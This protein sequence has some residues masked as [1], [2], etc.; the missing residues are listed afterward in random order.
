MAAVPRGSHASPESCVNLSKSIR[1]FLKF[2]GRIVSDRGRFSTDRF[3]RDFC[4][5]I[6]SGGYI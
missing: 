1:E 5:T 4:Q 3:R 6:L 2:T